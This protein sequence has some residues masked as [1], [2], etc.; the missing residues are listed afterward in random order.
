[1]LIEGRARFR[2]PS[3]VDGGVRFRENERRF[4]SV[5]PE[6]ALLPT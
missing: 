6:P 5:G 4:Y 3:S 1:M 2:A